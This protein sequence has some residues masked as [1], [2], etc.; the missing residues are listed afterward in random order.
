MRQIS[1]HK[2]Y[3]SKCTTQISK[4]SKQNPSPNAIQIIEYYKKSICSNLEDVIKITK[5]GRIID[6]KDL[7]EKLYWIDVNIKSIRKD[8]DRNKLL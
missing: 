1:K 4:K 7:I 2:P 3:K 5:S 8:L 6:S